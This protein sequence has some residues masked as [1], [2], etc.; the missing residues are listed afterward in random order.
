MMSW[1]SGVLRVV[2]PYGFPALGGA[3]AERSGL[4]TLCLEGALLLGAFV[5]A[6]VDIATG[7]AVCA[8]LAALL[9]GAAFGGL[10]AWLVSRARVDAVVSGIALN[11][12]V[13][14]ATRVGLKVLYGS[15]SNSPGTTQN[16]AHSMV[17]PALALLLVV[18]AL[19]SD[20]VLARTGVGLRVRAAGDGSE[21]ARAVGVSPER[22]RSFASA[23][24][25]GLAALG[26][27][28]LVADVH[29]FQSGMSAGRGFLALVAI[30]IAGNRPGRAVLVATSFGLLELLSGRF[31]GAVPRLAEWVP[32]LPYV[33]ALLVV[34]WP[35]R[36]GPHATR[37]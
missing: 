33:A 27:V 34:A 30:V 16:I 4:V 35:K 37:S 31:Q 20:R 19:G 36:A 5:Y 18:G 26:G 21:A 32:A 17:V 8:L 3:W 9:S 25:C 24:A 1:F 22:V 2:I 12:A 28:A 23:W 7:S 15:S 10:H 13:Y 11:A 6:G 14:G 29:R